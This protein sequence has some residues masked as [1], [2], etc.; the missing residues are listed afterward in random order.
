MKLRYKL[1]LAMLFVAV[2]PLGIAGYQALESSRT[3]VEERIREILAKTSRAEAEIIGRDT[4]EIFRALRLVASAMEIDTESLSSVSSGLERVY[5]LSDRFNAAAVFDAAG[6]QVGPTIFVDERASFGPKYQSHE[7]MNDQELK[8]FLEHVENTLPESEKAAQSGVYVS[9]RKS[10]PLVALLMPVVG[11]GD[12]GMTLAVE[13]SLDPVQKRFERFRVG[14]SGFAFLVD[15]Q[16]KLVFHPDL[17][18]VVARENLGALSILQ[19][20]LGT[21]DAAVSGYVDPQLGDMLGSF[22]PVPNSPWAVV[23]AQPQAEALEP[24]KALAT[25]L[26]TWLL[27]GLALAGLIGMLIAQRVTRPIMELVAGALAIAGGDLKKKIRVR[28]SDEIGRL[29]ETFNYMGDELVK[30]QEEIERWN[31][32]LQDRVEAR[33]RELKEAQQQLIQ[34][35]KMAAVGELGAGVAHE[36][37]NP[38]MGV[39]GCSQLLLMRHPEGDPDFVMLQDIEREAQRIRA[40]VSGLLE[41]SQTGEPGAGKL[42]LRSLVQHI[43]EQRT[44]ELRSKGVRLETNIP[45]DLPP[46]RGH[47]GQVE[48]VISELITN[49]KNSTSAGGLVRISASGTAGEVVKLEIQDTGTGIAPEHIDRIFEPF[50]TTKQNWQ[51]KGLGL[52]SAYKIVQKHNGKISVASEQG[53]GTTF[54][55]TFP[56]LQ[57][58][59]HLR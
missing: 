45:E 13:L 27:L 1:I 6:N 30:H 2:A 10:V 15:A 54:T 24:V 7:E 18:R 25:R 20:R 32:E 57:K 34:A 12:I 50:F 4:E 48:T 14:R 42:D 36:I 19:G 59:M 3:A 29:S 46:I 16:G 8:A 49:A 17:K 22:A 41:T 9:Q 47:S 33:T 56:A 52:A 55:I 23:V 51:G 35:K 44:T 38:L 37:N 26:V 21:T 53:K 28:S 40:I 11:A 31:V 5:L 58:S 43:V 39:L